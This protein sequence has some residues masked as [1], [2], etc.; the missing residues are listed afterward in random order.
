MRLL[1][2][3][4]I[5]DE[6]TDMLCGKGH[7]VLKPSPGTKDE[8]IAAIAKK[9]RRVILTQ[10]KDFA[11]IIW[12]PPKSLH[13]IIRIKFHPPIISDILV[14]LEN[15]FQEFTQKDLDKKLIILEKDGFRTRE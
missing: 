3:E 6:L 2:D 10:D 14:A 15:L 13:G 11:N 7:D 5:A 12:Y 1:I 4:N 9:E 8:H